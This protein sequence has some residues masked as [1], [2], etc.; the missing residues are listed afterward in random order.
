MTSSAIMVVIVMTWLFGVLAVNN[1][2][3][4]I[5]HYFFIVFYTFQVRELLL[6]SNDVPLNLTPTW[7]GL[8]GDWVGDTLRGVSYRDNTCFNNP[9]K[10]YLP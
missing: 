1:T 6:S 5:Y 2:E 9:D 8:E 7:L 4:K 10:F 3:D